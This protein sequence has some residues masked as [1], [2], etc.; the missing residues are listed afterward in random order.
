MALL[1]M[2]TLSSLLASTSEQNLHKIGGKVS[3]EEVALFWLICKFLS[4]KKQEFKAYLYPSEKGRTDNIESPF[5]LITAKSTFMQLSF[6]V[7]RV[8]DPNV[9]KKS[10]IKI[11]FRSNEDIVY[12]VF[13]YQLQEMKQLGSHTFWLDL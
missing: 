10:G 2:C 7:E 1:D 13:G 4:T 6:D 11:S 3:E 12:E 9:R 8:D 5:T